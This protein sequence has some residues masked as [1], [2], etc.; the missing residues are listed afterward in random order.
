MLLL[1][2]PKELFL[3]AEFGQ[4]DLKERRCCKFVKIVV[5]CNRILPTAFELF[6]A[7]TLA[8]FPY[9]SCKYI[10]ATVPKGFSLIFLN[11][12]IGN[13]LAEKTR[14]VLSFIFKYIV[15]YFVVNWYV[16][17][18]I[19]SILVEQ[20]GMLLILVANKRH[21]TNLSCFAKTYKNLNRA[22]V[23]YRELQMLCN[24]YNDLH[25]ILLTP[26][27]I[28]ACG[29]GTSAGYSMLTSKFFEKK[30]STAILF[31]NLHV[32]CIT[33][34]IPGFQ[35]A[36]KFLVESKT[37]TVKHCNWNCNEI[38]RH[39][40]NSHDRKIVARC[41]RSFPVIRILFFKSNFFEGNTSQVIANFSMWDKPGFM[42]KV[43]R[44]FLVGFD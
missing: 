9:S 7:L 13:L 24:V 22:L 26:A 5:Q 12:T 3:A 40:P 25:K 23:I 1:D 2:S 34:I 37:L 6:D 28:L 39:L 17:M 32:M 14:G 38:S 8:I 42:R 15:A 18:S 41:C 21:F 19:A 35:S 36:P 4:D 20:V 16:I 43:A 31:G 11:P 33:G 10:P 29:T 27:P 44:C 30:I